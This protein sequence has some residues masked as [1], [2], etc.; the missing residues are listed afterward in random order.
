M[1]GVTHQ[2]GVAAPLATTWELLADLRNWAELMPGY[3]GLEVLSETDST[4]KIQGDIGI[5]N[6]LVTLDVQVTEWVERDHVGFSFKCREEPLEARGALRAAGAG[7]EATVLTF[8]LEAQGGGMLGP[9][10]NALLG[11]VLPKLAAD[12]AGRIKDRLE[13]RQHHQVGPSV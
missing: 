9:V 5:L 4:W 8:W 7:P 2:I 10:V 3:R 11:K 13:T 12:F 1:P 6:K